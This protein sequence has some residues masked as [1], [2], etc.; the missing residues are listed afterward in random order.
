VIPIFVGH[1]K[2]AIARKRISWQRMAEVSL[3][4]VK[5]QRNLQFAIWRT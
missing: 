5:Q 1:E 2:P 4:L 3:N